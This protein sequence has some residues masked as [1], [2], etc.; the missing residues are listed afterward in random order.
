[1]AQKIE[2]ATKYYAFLYIDNGESDDIDSYLDREERFVELA[3]GA[4]DI[5]VLSIKQSMI[6]FRQYKREPKIRKLGYVANLAKRQ[7][8]PPHRKTELKLLQSDKLAIDRQEALAILVHI[9]NEVR[10]ASGCESKNIA[11]HETPLAIVGESS[12]ESAGTQSNTNE[13]VSKSSKDKMNTF[14]KKERIHEAMK[15]WSKHRHLSQAAIMKMFG[16]KDKKALSRPYAM[17]LK[18]ELFGKKSTPK[19]VA[20]DWFNNEKLKSKKD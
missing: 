12:K 20:D 10:T 2:R 17:M 11:T 19:E 14:E 8:I 16:F 1:M 13:V 18:K 6:V 3:V 9:A 5:G 15:H 4:V 7:S